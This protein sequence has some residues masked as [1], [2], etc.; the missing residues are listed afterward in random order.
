[1]DSTQRFPP[2]TT[3]PE[4]WTEPLPGTGI[5]AGQVLDAAGAP[6]P[7]ARVYGLVKREPAET[8]FSFAETYGEHGHPH[9]LY[10]EHFAVGD[11]PEGIY[12]R[13]APRSGGSG[14]CGGSRSSRASSPGSCCG[15]ERVFIEL[16][17]H[18]RCPADHEESYLVLLPDRIEDR[19]V[20]DGRLGCPVCGRTFVLADG[21][22]DLVDAAPPTPAPTRHVSPPTPL[23]ALAGLGGPGGYLVLVGAPARR[24]AGGRGAR[25]RGRRWWR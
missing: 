23:A 18:L 13:R 8:P 3:N 9:P 2:Y 25:S 7:Q 10:Q 22:L 19:S 14:C 16:T 20:R 6:V 21:V 24:L 1:M 17:D 4:L 5:V 15:P 12:V 11:V